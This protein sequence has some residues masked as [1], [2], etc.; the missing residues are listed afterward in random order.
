MRH[1]FMS[2]FTEDGG[3]KNGKERD[4]IQSLTDH[5]EIRRSNKTLTGWENIID[6]GERMMSCVTAY[7]EGR[8]MSGGVRGT[9]LDKVRKKVFAKLEGL[10]HASN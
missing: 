1:E 10:R 7:K 8:M 6:L 2:K 9:K 3:V 5:L 4:G